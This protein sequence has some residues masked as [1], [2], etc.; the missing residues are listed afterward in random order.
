MESAPK[1]AVDLEYL[2]TLHAPGAGPPH[3]IDSSLSIYRIGA[4]GWVRG[5]KISGR[6]INPTADWLRILPNGSFRVDA[7]MTVETDDGAVI[8]IAYG[9]VI[10]VTRANLERMTAGD[11]LTAADMYFITAPVFQTSHESYAW[12]NH[13]QAVGKV[14]AVR[15]GTGGK[16]GYVTYDVFAAR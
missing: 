8:Y 3:Q 10:S 1:T 9:G 11:E 13:I 4:E 2:M 7:R 12:L 6:M 5:P 14:V 16:A 15:G